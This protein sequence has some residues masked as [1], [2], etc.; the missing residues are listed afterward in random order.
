MYDPTGHA[1]WMPLQKATMPSLLPP[2]T[3]A[4]LYLV[5]HNKPFCTLAPQRAEQL[6]AHVTAQA[7]Q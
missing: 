1:S 2:T 7:Q 4:D 3:D 6:P 5:K